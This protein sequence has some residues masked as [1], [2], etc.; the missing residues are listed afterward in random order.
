MKV[1]IQTVNMSPVL[2]D[3]KKNMEMMKSSIEEDVD[4]AVF[5]ELCLTG[6]SIRDDVAYMAES[7]DGDSVKNMREIA[8][9]TGTHIIFG[10]AERDGRKVFNSAV[11]VSPDDRVWC[12]RKHHPVNFGPFEEA[13]YFTP[14]TELPVAHTS[15]GP[16]GMTICYDTFF[17]EL[18]KSLALMGAEIVVNIAASPHTTRVFFQ[19]VLP[20]RAIENTIFAVF[21]NNVGVYNNM[22]FWGGSMIIDPWGNTISSAD[23]F[24]EDSAVA[25]IDTGYLD[26]ARRMRPTLQDTPPGFLRWMED[27]G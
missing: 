27:Q 21:S 12:Y 8:V 20:A 13:R 23:M 15:L 22:M 5:P 1:S 9:D 6:Y 17:P 18:T 11:L 19:K 3:K 10:M 24:R 2:G 7:L 14:G 26:H 16:I 4:L 25:T